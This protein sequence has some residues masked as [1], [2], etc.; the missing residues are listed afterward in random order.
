LFKVKILTGE[1]NLEKSYKLLKGAIDLHIHTSPDVRERVVDD[2]EAA[3]QARDAGMR[4]IV[5]KCHDAITADRAYIARK[6]VP[7]IDVFG[8]VCLDLPVGG[9]NPYAIESAVKFTP[10]LPLTKIV[11]MPT[12]DAENWVLKR[13]L[14]GKGIPIVR[15]GNLV[16]DAREVLNAIARFNLTLATG[17]LSVDEIKILIT[18]AK[19]VGVKKIIVNHPH[20]DVIN[21]TIEDQKEV[22]K[23]GA[24]L[25]HC[26]IVCHQCK[27]TTPERVAEAI[28]AVGAE[29]CIMATDFG[30]ATNPPPVEGMRMFI[31]SMLAL[32][33]SENEIEI[34]VK[35]NPA[36][37]LE[38]TN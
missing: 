4:A 28:K 6:V 13:G 23:M 24:Y 15:N 30:Q 27:Y 5:L 33:I 37:I 20:L 22:A 1:S 25:E 31:S 21:M 17:H 8:G 2:I 14:K 34:M 16:S 36:R 9:L 11:W 26:F 29:H 19:N 38:L 7:G 10:R 32:G 18:E 35:R 3:K 12:F